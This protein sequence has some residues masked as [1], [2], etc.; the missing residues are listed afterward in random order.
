MPQVVAGW[1]GFLTLLRK[2][3]PMLASQVSMAELKSIKDNELELYF[4]ASGEASYQLAS[5]P[6]NVNLI[7]RVLRDHFRTGLKVRMTLNRDRSSGGGNGESAR[8]QKVDPEELLKRSPRLKSLVE[9]V[10]G[11][12]IGIR[13]IDE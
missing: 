6:D 13:K 7:I 9:K 3:S 4:P 1:D 12:I 11:E 2:T 10:N 8:R 5:K